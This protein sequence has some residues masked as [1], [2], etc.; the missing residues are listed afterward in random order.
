[1]MCYL[2]RW[3][4]QPTNQDQDNVWGFFTQSIFNKPQKI[5]IDLPFYDCRQN[6]DDDDENNGCLLTLRRC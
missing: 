4:W 6:N 5:V 1:M 3:P 2:M